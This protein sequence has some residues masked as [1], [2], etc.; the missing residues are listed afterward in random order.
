MQQI[1]LFAT[2]FLYN[3]ENPDLSNAN[4][5]AARKEHPMKNL[6]FTLCL[7]FTANTIAACCPVQARSTGSPLLPADAASVSQPRSVSPYIAAAKVSAADSR[8]TIRQTASK[9]AA[10][11][12]R[13]FRYNGKLYMD[14]G[15]IATGGRC[16]V[17]DGTI[18]RTVPANKV[19]TKELQSNF[20]TC[21][22]QYGR[23]E[24]RL[25]VLIND[26]WHIFACNEN[27]LD[28]ITMKV[29]KNNARAAKLEIENTTDLT[30]TFGA[31][32]EL[33]IRDRKT[34]NWKS[35]P[36]RSDNIGFQ[37]IGYTAK[38]NRVTTWQVNWKK[39]YGTLK[40]G[41]YR[42]VKSFFRNHKNDVSTTYILTASF[43]VPAAKPKSR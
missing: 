21:S 22:F 27:N 11:K 35:V 39:R 36:Y 42:I 13:M 31:D 16:G 40:P 6:P 25:E 7:L 19:P 34:N 5:S 37:S 2:L 3:N 24:N 28:G 4:F 29:T 14:T 10:P 12:K 18:E 26:T 1:G 23:R 15:E 30:I 38:K 17:M 20:G 9:K 41:T 32:Y 33:E 8:G 43:T